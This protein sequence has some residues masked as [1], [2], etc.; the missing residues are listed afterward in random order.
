MAKHV[1]LFNPS[2]I[3]GWFEILNLSLIEISHNQIF[4]LQCY[5]IYNISS[6]LIF[7]KEYVPYIM[8]LFSLI[9]NTRSAGLM[10]L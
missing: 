3:V 1:G 5:K 4:N 2:F 10:Y 8:Y 9:T 7:L 6:L